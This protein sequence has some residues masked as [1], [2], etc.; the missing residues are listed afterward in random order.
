MRVEGRDEFAQ[1]REDKND[2]PFPPQE[3]GG[4]KHSLLHQTT[5]R[6]EAKICQIP[7]RGGRLTLHSRSLKIPA[8]IGKSI[9]AS[10]KMS[11]GNSKVH[12]SS[13]FSNSRENSRGRGKFFVEIEK[14]RES[15]I[16]AS[17]SLRIDFSRCFR[18]QY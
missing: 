10:P 6:T 7:S 18:Q 16:F 14:K 8:G 15:F 4:V 9:S 1:A 3:N 11:R 2:L 17:P 12:S 5:V 13:R